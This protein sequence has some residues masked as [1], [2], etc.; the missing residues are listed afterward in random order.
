MCLKTAAFSRAP[1]LAA[2][3]C[4]AM[5]IALARQHWVTP[6]AL[7]LALAAMAALTL[8]A[9]RYALRVALLPLGCLFLLLGALCCEVAPQPD[10]Q[11]A[12]ALLANHAPRTLEA[13]IVRLG[14]L[15]HTQ[16]AAPFTGK[17]RD[18]HT[19]QIDLRVLAV[20]DN[21]THMKPVTGGLRLHL[22]APASAMFPHLACGALLQVT[23]AMHEEERYLDPGVWDS[24]AW[25]RAQGIGALASS[26][27]SA[28]VV[29]SAGHTSEGCWLR[30]M[31]QSASDRLIS[32][33]D[34]PHRLPKLLRLDHD[35]ASMLTAM[36]TGDRSWLERRVRTG[37]ERTGS[38]HLLVV[39][40]MHLAIF[41]GF[42]FLIAGWLRMPRTL[43]TV[44]TI[45]LSFGYALFTGFGQ[46][47]ER[48]FWMV[49]LYLLG[50][51][52]WRERQAM[53][54]VGFAALFLLAASPDA[55]FQTSFQMT[56]LSVIAIA[57]IATPMAERTFAPYLR[58]MRSL[59]QREI[60]PSLPPKVAQFR[61]M[62]RMIADHLTPFI[63]RW[64]AR[65]VLP[66]AIRMALRILELLLVSV[67]IELVMSLPMALSFH[68]IT[69]LA[70]P[71]N[72]L[73][74][75]FVAVLLPAAILTFAVLLL[76]HQAAFVPAAFTAL[77][78]HGVLWI[79][80]GFAHLRAG[81]VRVPDPRP[82]QIAAWMLLLVASIWAARRQRFAVPLA[83]CALLAA[84][85]CVLWPMRMLHRRDALSITAID[86]GQGDSLLVIT[87][88]GK[89]LLIDAGG[90]VGAS[91]ESKFDIGED[92]VSPLLW[93]LGIRRLDAVA[94]THAHEDH[95][96]GMAS[97]LANFRPR[98]LWTGSNPNSPA[99]DA[100]IAEAA[101]EGAGMHHY[102]A[103]DRFR[104]GMADVAVLSPAVGYKPGA[105]AQNDDSLVLRLSYGHTSALLEG[106]AEMQ[107]ERAMVAL[108][109]L[110]SDLLKVGHHGSK[111]ST[112]AWF[113]SAVSPSYAVISVGQHNFYG[114]PKR[115]VLQELESTHVKTFRTDTVGATTFYLDGAHVTAAP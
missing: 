100:L 55:L 9:R 95:I 106:D 28:V 78:L 5:G 64:L 103:G 4:F 41:A 36:L 10:P 108:G 98:E 88:D 96:G 12:L 2:A 102:R 71:V 79:V 7:L 18:E 30:S 33:A 94:I 1:M 99:Y 19:Q 56:L 92:V 48:S 61:V 47:V 52:L 86:V 46:P 67:T 40:G 29:K 110:R 51:L 76:A 114:H 104:F 113:L 16:S 80:Q 58:A 24:G 38:F 14:P 44:V 3:C 62:L 45:A 72:F 63:G 57:G 91:P 42:V 13:E 6:A 112:N 11:Q 65:S 82:I 90:I 85:G 105:T 21:P 31:Q 115:A 74:V 35:D 17:L 109:G 73:I 53:N 43:A 97:V 34:Q 77:V 54:A 93:S 89:T 60:D 23:T 8:W 20:G 83:A 15:K 69:A 59:W 50:R 87:P 111:T 32:Y 75:P 81:D 66:F 49:T 26:P 101:Q 68:R 22:Y 39:S 27:A 84:A 70:L 25:L 107:S 37:F